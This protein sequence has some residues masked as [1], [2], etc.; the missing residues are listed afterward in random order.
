MTG[1][2]A[3]PVLASAVVALV[4]AALGACVYYPTITDVGGIRIQPANGRVVRQDGGAAFFA[5]INSTGKFDDV[6]T[7]V[8]TVVARHAQ[9]V[10]AAGAPLSR[11]RVPGT[12][13]VR[14]VPDGRHVVLSDL[15]RDLK[16]GEVVIVTIFFEKTG[17]IGV[18]ALV[19]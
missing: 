8:E 4:C 17:A 16:A 3:A 15:T 1:A 11:L 2:R 19:E 12:T 14:L 7:R 6:L 5:D 13:L 10:D 18:I 9:L